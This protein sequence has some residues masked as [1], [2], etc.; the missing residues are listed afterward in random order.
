M[1]ASKERTIRAFCGQKPD[2]VPVGVFLGGSWPIIKSG[3]TLQGLIG[4]PVRTA[5]VFYEVNEELDADLLMVGTGATALIIRALG[6][7]VRFNSKGAPDI[8][9]ELIQTEADLDRLDVATAFADPAVRWLQ[10]TAGELYAL[11]GQHRLI[12]ASGRA[13]FTLASQLYG[14]ENL[15]RAMYRNKEFVH[16]LLEFA[17]RLSIGY[18]VPHLQAGIV[19]G[20]FIADPSASGDLISARHFAEFV[21]PYTE[22]VVSAVKKAGGLTM[23]HICGDITD[24]LHLIPDIRVDNL[25]VDTKVS[26]AAAKNVLGTRVSLSGNVDPVGI[27]EFGT[28]AEVRQATVTCLEPGAGAGGFILLPGCDLAAGVAVENIRAFVE[29]GRSWAG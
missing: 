19:D 10:E 5:R 4:D 7:E 11:A 9:S 13:P 16:R 26:I 15:A 8:L 28:A 23:L 18:F 6:G 2:R 25:S 20:A 1:S 14:V 27:L 3:L 29:T 12:L 17:T 24:R 21:L 22:Q